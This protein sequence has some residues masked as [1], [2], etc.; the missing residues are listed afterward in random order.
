[1][2]DGVAAACCCRCWAMTARW[3]ISIQ[4]N[5]TTSCLFRMFGCGSTDDIISSMFNNTGENCLIAPYF[6]AATRS[7]SATYKYFQDCSMPVRLISSGVA[8]WR[9]LS[10]VPYCELWG[11]S[12]RPFR[13][14]YQLSWMENCPIWKLIVWMVLRVIWNVELSVLLVFVYHSHRNY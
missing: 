5:A 2:D 9:R 14:L 8:V 1:M 7:S 12:Q 4:T 10:T 3:A 11:V 6:S 13:I